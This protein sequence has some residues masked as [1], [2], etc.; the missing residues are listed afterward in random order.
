MFV[1]NISV[2]DYLVKQN[3]NLKMGTFNNSISRGSIG[4]KDKCA[5][6][7][8]YPMFEPK[9]ITMSPAG[10]SSK[11]FQP[12]PFIIG[13]FV[14]SK[15]VENKNSFANYSDLLER[16]INILTVFQEPSNRGGHQQNMSDSPKEQFKY[17]VKNYSRSAG[18]WGSKTKPVTFPHSPHK[19]SDSTNHKL[20]SPVLK[21]NPSN[22][23]TDR[24][25]LKFN[26]LHQ[27]MDSS[28]PKLDSQDS[29]LNQPV[30]NLNSSVLKFDS[31]GGR[32]EVDPVN[33]PS[34]SESLSIP[35]KQVASNGCEVAE[36]G[37]EPTVDNMADIITPGIATVVGEY[38][39]SLPLE[40]ASPVVPMK[41]IAISDC[42]VMECKYEPV[43]GAAIPAIAG[44]MTKNIILPE[45]K[46]SVSRTLSECTDDSWLSVESD[47]SCKE[48]ISSPW[49]R[50]MLVDVCD[51]G[52]S[53]WDS[54][55]D[56]VSENGE[57]VDSVKW[58][59]DLLSPI[60]SP[61]GLQK[62]EP[63]HFSY[64]YDSDDDDDGD[65]V[66]ISCCPYGGFDDDDQRD[67]MLAKKRIELINRKW[68][69]DMLKSSDEIDGKP[70][71]KK[72][73]VLNLS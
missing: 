47:D 46:K 34:D 55:D 25:T 63:A 51:D 50:S 27:N 61:I 33:Q 70:K 67:K 19:K 44:M 31:E 9:F 2:M 26:T 43:L 38:T 64:E 54:V 14:G 28:F 17:P 37:M 56:Y 68:D 12:P 60:P 41:P 66:T 53:D 57:V 3:S 73:T 39:A 6:S 13:G 71:T 21:L 36:H 22:M 29:Q 24:P 20:V 32:C 8:S 48:V 52:D 15:S 45:I 1:S 69:E 72:K 30:M 65:K 49:L 23:N 16:F 7:S 5:L 40:S 42:A 10:V 4:M 35:F 62:E 11:L 18:R 59:G 58:N